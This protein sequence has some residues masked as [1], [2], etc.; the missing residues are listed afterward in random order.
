MGR[1]KLN[2]NVVI[3]KIRFLRLIEPPF[4]IKENI[5]LLRPFKIFSEESANNIFKI[6]EKASK[7]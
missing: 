5:I 2:T 3:F 1:R 7:S 6:I 4:E